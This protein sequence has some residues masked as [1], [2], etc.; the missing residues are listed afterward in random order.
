MLHQVFQLTDRRLGYPVSASLPVL[1]I[2]TRN[3]GR[4]SMVLVCLK[5]ISKERI[6]SQSDHESETKGE[7]VIQLTEC[8][9]FKCMAETC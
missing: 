6:Q 9:C 8:F 7:T 1:Y 3:P 2:S 4:T 5:R